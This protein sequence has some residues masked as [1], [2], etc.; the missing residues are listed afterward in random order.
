MIRDN[1]IKKGFYMFLVWH[2][3]RMMTFDLLK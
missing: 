1:L 3:G 2:C